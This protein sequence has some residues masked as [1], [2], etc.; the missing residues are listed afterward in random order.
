MPK[1]MSIE[2]QLSLLAEYFS[3]EAIESFTG[4]LPQ[5]TLDEL[6][7]VVTL[8][9]DKMKKYREKAKQGKK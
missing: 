1:N 7:Q 6:I 5:E 3:D 8:I 4:N 9:D 2:E